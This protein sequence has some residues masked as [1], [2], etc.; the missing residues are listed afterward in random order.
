MELL[1]STHTGRRHGEALCPSPGEGSP[2][3][4]EMDSCSLEFSSCGSHL[5]F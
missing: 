3:L 4:R 5:P 2:Y 1:G